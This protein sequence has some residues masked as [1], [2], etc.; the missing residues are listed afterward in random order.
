MDRSLLHEL[1]F[2]TGYI[3]ENALELGSQIDQSL[4]SLEAVVEDEVVPSVGA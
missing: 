4:H 1:E 2:C 3:Q